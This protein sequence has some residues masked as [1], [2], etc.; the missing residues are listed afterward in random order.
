MEAL[1]KSEHDVKIDMHIHTTASDG[2]WTIEQLIEN[3]ILNDIK[4]FSVT[5]HD[6]LKNTEKAGNLAIGAGLKF[7]QG[8]EINTFYNKTNYHILGYGIDPH[9]K[10]L[11]ELT[12]KNKKL[13]EA[14][15]QKSISFLESKGL[16]VALE[17]YLEYNNDFSRGGWKALNYAIDKGLCTNYIEFM[18]ILVK[19]GNPFEKEGFPSPGEAIEVIIAAGG[20]PVLAHP[21]A[22]FYGSDFMNTIQFILGQGI[23]GIECY[24]PE[25]NLEVLNYCINICKSKKLFIT[26][27]SDCHGDFVKS[28]KL[29]Q[30]DIRL[31][32][33]DLTNGNRSLITNSIGTV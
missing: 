19:W 32:M 22:A 30:P 26:G 21:G 33:L 5:D 23:K 27:G 28:R 15:N 13:L 10:G 12:L 25:N 7:I 9:N 18:Q 20:I 8:I 11:N 24:H 17:E 3:L 4:I 1:S 31:A 29:G 6:S 16:N 14:N 2:T